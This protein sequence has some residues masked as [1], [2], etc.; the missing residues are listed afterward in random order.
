M[1]LAAA[2]DA[3]QTG[4]NA[5][6]GTWF[7]IIAAALAGAA[8]RWIAPIA[9]FLFYLLTHT[10]FF[11]SVGHVGTTFIWVLVAV[12]LFVGLQLGGR[13]IL[14]HLGE[15]EYRVRLGNVKTIS[16]LWQFWP[17]DKTPS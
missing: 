8:V 6:G 2:H 1:F 15:R 14:R 16:S 9:I 7:I 10:A 11:H 4:I 3:A 5:S 13:T 17:G 12:A